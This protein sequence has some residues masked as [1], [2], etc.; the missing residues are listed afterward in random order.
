MYTELILY[1][2]C[3]N[4]VPESSLSIWRFVRCIFNQQTIKAFEEKGVWTP[5]PITD[6]PVFEIHNKA[7]R[8]GP[9]GLETDIATIQHRACHEMI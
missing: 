9:P 7:A 4:Q 6:L 8:C 3:Q 5:W 2:G 1:Q